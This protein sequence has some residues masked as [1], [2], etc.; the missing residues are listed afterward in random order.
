[1]LQYTLYRSLLK[2][3]DLSTKEEN[4]EKEM[5]SC[6]RRKENEEAEQVPHFTNYEV[7]SLIVFLHPSQET[8]DE[9]ATECKGNF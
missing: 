4:K 3:N 6:E 7:S 8:C 1:M 2:E 5:W 9:D